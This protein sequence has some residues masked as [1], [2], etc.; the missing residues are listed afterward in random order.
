MD[1]FFASLHDLSSQQDSIIK[2]WHLAQKSA[3]KPH[4]IVDHLAKIILLV[5]LAFHAITVI[6]SWLKKYSVHLLLHEFI[7]IKVFSIIF[8]IPFRRKATVVHA[9]SFLML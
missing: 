9:S 3:S 8:L 7:P 1:E 6:I 5:S 4:H 2:F